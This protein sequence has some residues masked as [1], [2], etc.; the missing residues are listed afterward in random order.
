MAACP[1]CG[2]PRVRRNKHKLRKCGRCGVLGSN[3]QLDRGG[4]KRR[5]AQLDARYV[6]KAAGATNAELP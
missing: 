5:A 4:M 3:R 2:K 6:Y 1:K